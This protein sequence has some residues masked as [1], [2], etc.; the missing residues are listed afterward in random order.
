[1][2]TINKKP[3]VEIPAKG[4]LNLKSGFLPKLLC[5]GPTFSAGVACVYSCAFCY[6]PAQMRMH[7]AV[8]EAMKKHGV[9]FEGLVVRRK[10]AV[11]VLRSQL[12]TA[13]GLPRFDDPADTRVVYSSPLVDVAATMEL[14]RETAAICKEIL[15]LTNWQIRLLTKSNLLPQLVALIEEKYWPRLILGVSTGTLD[16][17]LARVFEVGTALPSRRIASLHKLQSMGL[18]T[19]GMVCPSLPLDDYDAFSREAMAAINADKCEHVWAEVINVRG[20]SMTRTCDALRGGGFVKHARMLEDV[21]MNKDVWE[22]YARDTYLAHA[23]Y[24]PTDKLRYLQ[25][26]TKANKDWWS[27]KPGVVLL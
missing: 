3:V 13:K 7:G 17:S 16:D 26:I 22:Q 18:R 1:M 10:G 15:T 11:A 12:L 5:D 23:K 2:L 9:G 25:Y 27:E 14:V 21:S 20:E 19:Y 4:V 24:A 8:Q 6:V